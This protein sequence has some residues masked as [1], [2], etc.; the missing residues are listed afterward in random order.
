MRTEWYGRGHMARLTAIGI[1][2]AD[3]AASCRFYRALGIDVADPE[4]DADHHETTLPDALRLMWDREQLIKQISPG[5]TRGTG[6]DIGLAFECD[7]P[8]DVDAVYALALAAGGESH[9]EPYDAFWGQRYASVR[10][11]DGNVVDLFAPL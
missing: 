11:P 2:T 5:W 6:T 10:D 8:G 7:G 4:A 9:A 3:M 1:V